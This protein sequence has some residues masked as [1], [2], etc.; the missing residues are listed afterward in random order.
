MRTSH[1][2]R[3][4]S[5]RLRPHI[6]IHNGLGGRAMWPIMPVPPL[7]GHRAARQAKS[8]FS[9]LK[10][11][12]LA[13]QKR[14]CTQRVYVQQLSAPFHSG[15]ALGRAL[16][17]LRQRLESGSRHTRSVTQTLPTRSFLPQQ[18]EPA[19][20]SIDPPGAARH[21]PGRWPS[22]RALSNP[23]PRP[24]S[25]NPRARQILKLF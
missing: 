10:K 3:R 16:N 8:Q 23:L 22:R 1:G 17:S 12:K 2:E 9:V 4:P 7:F 11:R 24:D 15:R 13:A 6:A 21:P 19:C 18:P 14:R 5:A 20:A 25:L